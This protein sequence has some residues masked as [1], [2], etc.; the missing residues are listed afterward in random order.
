[1][2]FTLDNIAAHNKAQEEFNNQWDDLFQSIAQTIV[3]HPTRFTYITDKNSIKNITVSLYG[4]GDERMVHINFL[5]QYGDHEGL[6]V[7][8]IALDHPG[9]IVGYAEE[10]ERE[11]AEREQAERLRKA[12]E[13]SAQNRADMLAALGRNIHACGFTREELDAAVAQAGAE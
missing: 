5:D 11:R 10:Q 9:G 7:P 12:A 4:E 13:R 3:D 8:A 2:K 6:I 1:M